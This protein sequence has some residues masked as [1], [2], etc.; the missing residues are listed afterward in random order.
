MFQAIA[1][2]YERLAVSGRKQKIKR[3]DWKSTMNKVKALSNA[4]LMSVLMSTSV[5]WGTTA[6]AADNLQ[7]YS[8]DTMVVTATRTEKKLV[9]TPANAMVIT[10]EQI[11]DQGYSSAFE[12]VTSMTQ[13]GA[14]G[15]QDD[16]T[17][18]SGMLSRIRLRG[19]DN[20]TLVLVNG[21]P[22]KFLNASAFIC[23]TL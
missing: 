15:W 8:L 21:H 17:D 11:K 12:L 6:F 2:D 13:A 5:V 14:M 19:M 10:K 1:Q 9:D 23:L 18:Y 3:K 4:V 7:E 20:G 22:A 16:G